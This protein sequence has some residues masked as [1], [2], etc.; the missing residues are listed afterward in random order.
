M[1]FNQ[2]DGIPITFTCDWGL[3]AGLEA[4]KQPPKTKSKGVA[5][6]ASNCGNGGAD[7]RTAYVDELMKYIEVDSYGSS[8]SAILI[9]IGACL[10]NTDWPPGMRKP[11]YDDHGQSM[12]NKIKLFSDY[13]FV[14]AFENNNITGTSFRSLE[15][16]HP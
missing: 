1:T 12:A 14:L 4:L 3:K 9:R 2:N 13:K 7:K 16:Y 6:V 5:F 8:F 11:I 15:S 10:H